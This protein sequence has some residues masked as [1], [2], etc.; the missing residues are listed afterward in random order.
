VPA[1]GD[2]SEQSPEQ[3]TKEPLLDKKDVQLLLGIIFPALR[4]LED[5]KD[6]DKHDEVDHRDG[7]EKNHRNQRA[8]Q[9]AG[10]DQSGKAPLKAARRQGDQSGGRNHDGRVAKGKEEP[11]SNRP[12]ALLHQFACDVVDRGDV[13][14][15][16]RMSQPKAVGNK[17]RCQQ[18]GVAVKRR[19]GPNPG[20]QVRGD[21][22]HVERDHFGANMVG[23]VIENRARREGGSIL[24]HPR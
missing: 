17:R 9:G 21:Q 6:A 3:A 2:Q 18:Q 1:A 15:I 10:L 13:V 7:E 11:D 24:W 23:C 5:P 8:N 12:L 14:R 20:E 16:D 19:E 22:D 4:P